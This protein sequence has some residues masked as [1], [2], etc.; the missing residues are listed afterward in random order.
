MYPIPLAVGA[1]VATYV[2][3]RLLGHMALRPWRKSVGRHWTQRANL[4]YPAR[5]T[6]GLCLLVLPVDI[7]LALQWTC[8]QRDIP[9]F[10]GVGIVWLILSCA[11]AGS[12]L[13]H[14][15]F[16][17]TLYPDL[18]IAWHFRACFANLL[19]RG[20][21]VLV[22]CVTTFTMPSD[23]GLRTWLEAAMALAVL[24]AMQYGL[25]TQVL[26]WMRLFKPADDPLRK[27]VADIA[28]HMNVK[29]AKVWIF[30]T[31]P[32]NA[33]ALPVTQELIFS[34]TL[35][36]ELSDDQISAICAH[37]LG[38]L[39]E[40]RAVRWTRQIN[41]LLLFPLVFMYPVESLTHSMFLYP[42]IVLILA[43]GIKIFMARLGRRMEV[44][45]DSI[46][47]AQQAQPAVYARALEKLYQINQLPASMGRRKSV[48]PDLYDRMIAAGLTP[49]YA[50]PRPPLRH[51][52]WSMLLY[53]ALGVLCL[54]NLQQSASNLS[55]YNSRHLQQ[56]LRNHPDYRSAPDSRT[57]PVNGPIQSI[58]LAP[59]P[60]NGGDHLQRI[61]FFK[62]R[63]SLRLHYYQLLMK[64]NCL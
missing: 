20:V 57:G 28:G 6:A 39:T 22:L 4:L 1:F 13:A 8:L 16:A 38:H 36:K 31:L 18:K 42:V 3:S 48:H 61:Q 55:S 25:A 33:F 29:V 7:Y 35:L 17:R 46:A 43:L 54:M 47:C 27:L 58:P 41:A 52:T 49:D 23:F 34:S 40:S 59:A 12:F 56:W 5:V 30:Q 64:G 24:L 37:E 21:L 51:N 44:R 63:P 26:V 62:L 32:A 11:F 2:L 45:A 50:K 10:T 60:A 53:A 14:Q 19:L 15:S 9:H